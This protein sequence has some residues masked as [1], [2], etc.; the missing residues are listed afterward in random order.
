MKLGVVQVVLWSFGI[1]LAF[2]FSVPIAAALFPG[3]ATDLVMQAALL[4]LVYFA[5]CSL[6]AA[7]RPGRT[8]SE[9]FAL[10]K[11]SLWLVLISL[12]LGVVAS[13]PA[14]AL[15]GYVERLVPMSDTEEKALDE[16]M[17]PR[18]LAHAI[19]FFVF[20]AGI[21]PFAEELVYRGALYTG[22]RPGH[23]PAYAGWT[24]GA[25]FTVIHAEPRFWPSILALAGVLAFARAVSGSIWPSVFLHVAFNAT[26]LAMPEK[27]SLFENPGVVLVLG[28]L[29]VS[30]LLVAA[31]GF[32]GRASASADLARQVDLVPDPGLGATPS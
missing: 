31:L 20:V 28:S 10:R 29:V 9:T 8:W 12:A 5:G 11:T 2:L 19:A 7:R 14:H 21:G 17:T 26:A 13:L 3:L 1:Q 23:S 16:L 18:S 6:F 4:A 22:L 27:H 15:A 30:G 32:V 24:T 25:L